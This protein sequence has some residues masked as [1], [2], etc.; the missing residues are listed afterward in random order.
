MDDLDVVLRNV[1]R[2]SDDD[3]RK[4]SELQEMFSRTVRDREIDRT[5]RERAEKEAD[6]AGKI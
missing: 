3:R 1:R 5:A 4:G 2:I 6:G